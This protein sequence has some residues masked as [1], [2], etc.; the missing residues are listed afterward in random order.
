MYA[1]E[2]GY[3]SVFVRV[4]LWLNFFCCPLLAA[5]CQLAFVGLWLIFFAA[6]C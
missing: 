2:V 4:G 6:G 3:M 5:C 1:Y